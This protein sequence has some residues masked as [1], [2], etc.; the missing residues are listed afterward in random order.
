MRHILLTAVPGP[1][2]TA[3]W[4]RFLAI[5]PFATHYCT[6]NYFKDPYLPGNAFAVLAEQDNGEIAGV[7]TGVWDQKKAIS[8]LFVRP[9]TVFAADTDLGRAS[10]AILSGISELYDGR[11]GL[12]ELFSWLHVPQ[13]VDLG[14]N[15]R[16]G[17][18]A[19]CV[20]VLDLS[21]GAEKL[22]AQFSQTRRSEIRKSLR[23][24]IVAVKEL[25]TG[26]EFDQMDSIHVDWCDRKGHSPDS[27]E[28]MRTAVEDRENRRT[29]IAKTDA[30]VIAASFYRFCPGGVVEYAGNCSIPEYQNLRPNDLIS[31]HAIQWACAERFTHF[32]MGGSHLFLRRFG[33]EVLST[34][35]YSRDH[36]RLKL[37]DLRERT[38]EA[39]LD[40]YKRLPIRVRA[41]VKRVL[42]GR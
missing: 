18:G 9:Q 37:H 11:P 19:M 26:D 23:K 8:G 12:I 10:S 1:E 15:V 28:Q 27:L 40:V 38:R 41:N 34:Y 25:E 24:G 4:N 13:F 30:K 32:S 6:P 39:S 29:F 17:R 35:R 42:I 3:R 5:A 2:L 21:L 31:W 33:G 14:M 20:V 36:S 7:L 16:E 22:F